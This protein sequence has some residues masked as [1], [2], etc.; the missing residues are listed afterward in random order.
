VV[1]GFFAMSSA[2][3]PSVCRTCERIKNKKRIKQNSATMPEAREEEK[4]LGGIGIFCG[5]A[6]DARKDGTLCD[7]AGTKMT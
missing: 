3:G 4:L 5:A 7:I 1:I 2:D 6:R